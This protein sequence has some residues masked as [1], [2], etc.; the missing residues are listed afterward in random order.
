MFMNLTY[1]YTGASFSGRMPCSDIADSIVETGRTMLN[2]VI[3]KVNTTKEYQAKVVYG[4]T[5]SVFIHLQ[6]VSMEKAFVIG[7]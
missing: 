7:Q 3:Q 4:D 5:D 2:L 6:G 1:G